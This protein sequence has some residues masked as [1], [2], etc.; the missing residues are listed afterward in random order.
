MGKPSVGVWIT[1][2]LLHRSTLGQRGRAGRLG[3]KQGVFGQEHTSQ[4][5]S[6]LYTTGNT[7]H[8]T[9]LAL[10]YLK[11]QLALFLR[12]RCPKVSKI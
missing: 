12:C 10:I 5:S 6:V 4:V 3:H 2:S 11:E 1:S 7:C 8:V 9:K